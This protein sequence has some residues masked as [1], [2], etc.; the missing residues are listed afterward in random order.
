MFEM[1]ESAIH[2]NQH[3]R[4]IRWTLIVVVTSTVRGVVLLNFL[5][6][7]LNYK[8]VTEALKTNRKRETTLKKKVINCILVHHA[9]K[10]PLMQKHTDLADQNTSFSDHSMFIVP[11]FRPMTFSFEFHQRN[12]NLAPD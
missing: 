1:I 5:P 9:A 2:T 10:S 6:I 4:N 7:I 11:T 12:R 8:R 3:G